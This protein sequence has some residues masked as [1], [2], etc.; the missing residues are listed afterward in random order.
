MK[1]AFLIA[2]L[3]AAATLQSCQKVIDVNLNDSDPRY[4]IEGNVDDGPG[5]YHIKVSR[6][7]NFSTGNDFPAVS[8]ALVTITDVTA[9]LTDT[10]KEQAPGTYATRFL[11]GVPGHTYQ[12]YLKAGDNVFTATSVMP[13][14][15]V[16][17]SIYTEKSV[18]GGDDLFPVPVYRDPST[19]RN[20]YRLTLAVNRLPVKGSD[21]RSDAVTNGQTAKFPIY[22]NT[23]EESGNPVIRPGDSVFVSLQSIDSAVYEFFRTLE[24]T[25]DQSAA[26]LSNPVSNIKGGAMGYF[27]AAA[28]RSKSIL[29][30]E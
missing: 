7:V 24:D 29:V 19:T 20:Q 16:I 28:V 27:N 1:P 11:A 30:P 17:D 18:F 22:Y 26:A 15:V 13:Q 14:P 4:V 10:L 23:D 21:V 12:L 9:A 6:S 8:N 5:P 2:L 25:R 3:F